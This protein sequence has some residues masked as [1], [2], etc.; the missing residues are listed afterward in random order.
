M[1]KTKLES[2]IFDFAVENTKN[3]FPSSLSNGTGDV[4]LGMDM[5][6]VLNKGL[7]K[8][9]VYDIKEGEVLML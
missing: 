8:N 3:P 6:D 1:N 2:K 9:A 7:V 4:F 5:F